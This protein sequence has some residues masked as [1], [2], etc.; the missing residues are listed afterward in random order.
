MATPSFNRAALDAALIKLKASARRKAIAPGLYHLDLDGKVSR[1]IDETAQA[2]RGL[3]VTVERNGD[4][5]FFDE[6]DALFSKRGE[7]K[8]AHDRYASEERAYLLSR[9]DDGR[10]P[11]RLR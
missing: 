1:T 2:L 9:F 5:L 11:P 3:F 8:D 10:W 4:V 7:V 6:A